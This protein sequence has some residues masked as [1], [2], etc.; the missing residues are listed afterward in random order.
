MF[1]K[2]ARLRHERD[3][4]TVR[5]LGRRIRD[6]CLSV[7]VVRGSATQ[8]RVAVVVSKRVDRRATE[9]NR[10]KRQLR[11]IMARLYVRLPTNADVVVYAQPPAK[12]RSFADLR[13]RLQNLLQRLSLLT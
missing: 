13:A 8:A 4:E 11:S 2:R 7:R 5:R 3:H 6:Q 1:P 10:I 9:R 12:Q